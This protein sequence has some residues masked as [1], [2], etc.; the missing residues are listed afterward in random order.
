MRVSCKWFIE[1]PPNSYIK[2]SRIGFPRRRLRLLIPHQ[3]L[4]Q[5]LQPHLRRCKQLLLR[6]LECV[7]YFFKNQIKA[8]KLKSRVHSRGLL[9]LK[10]YEPCKNIPE[11]RKM[12]S[13]L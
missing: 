13:T 9:S 5:I 6:V 10:L 1:H 8:V 11:N 2:D 3:P 12:E 4:C 7:F